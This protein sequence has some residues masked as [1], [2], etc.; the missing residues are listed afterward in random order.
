[1]A[2]PLRYAV[3]LPA[4]ARAV[5]LR[6]DV[7]EPGARCVVALDEAGEE[8]GMAAAGVSRE[9]DAPTAW[10]L[11]S[12]N[13]V[14]RARGSGVADALLLA[15]LDDRDASLWVVADN[16]RALGFYRRHGFGPDGV[17]RTHPG[18]GDDEIRMVRPSQALSRARRPG[19][20]W[21]SSPAWRAP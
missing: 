13:T 18:T 1:V 5:R 19:P 16:E 15:V 9:E 4:G 21:S 11:Y 12:I 6:A 7:D 3:L 20:R 2:E 8:V 14:A 17:R 10:E